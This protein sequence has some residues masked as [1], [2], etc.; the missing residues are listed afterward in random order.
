MLPQGM[1]LSESKWLKDSR[2]VKEYIDF[3]LEGDGRLIEY[4]EWIGDA[5]YSYYLSSGD[6]AYIKDKLQPLINIWNIRHKKYYDENIGLFWLT[7]QED[8][9]EN[10][11][12]SYKYNDNFVNTYRPTVNSYAYSLGKSN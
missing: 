10:N 4:S 5:A 12:T 6:S 8:A 1:L 9:M 2:Y 3:F 11:S 7:P